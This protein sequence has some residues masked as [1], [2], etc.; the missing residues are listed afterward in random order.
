MSASRSITVII[1]RGVTAICGRM[2][3][4]HL[5]QRARRC[6]S[7]TLYYAER[8]HLIFQTV[9]STSELLGLENIACLHLLIHV[10]GRIS[11]KHGKPTLPT[12]ECI[13]VFFPLFRSIYIL[14][15]VSR[16]KSIHNNHGIMRRQSRWS[17]QLRKFE[18]YKLYT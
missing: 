15:A 2:D 14:T 9:T 11:L 13:F 12:C 5:Y 18:Q 4:L 6:P 7:S 10:L 3:I 1:A 16:P 8:F 17:Q